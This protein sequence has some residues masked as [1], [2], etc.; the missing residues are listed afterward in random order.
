MDWPAW[1]RLGLALALGYGAWC[2]TF[3]FLQDRMIYPIAG[4]PGSRA[5]VPPG[6][7]VLSRSI[8]GGE[9]SAWFYPPPNPPAP[10]VI[11]FHGNGETIAK[12]GE[13]AAG[14]ARLG[15]GLLLVEYRGYG[16]S[17]GRPSQRSIVE[18]AVWFYDQLCGRPEVDRE[19]IVLHGRSL[20]GGFAVQLA[21]QRPAAGLVLES[22]FTSIAQLARRFGVPAGLL[23]TPLRT[24]EAL[25]TL[26]LPVLI[27]HGSRDA[28]V[29][30]SHGRALRDL[31]R[32][33]TYLE[34]PRG[35]N[36]LPGPE[37]AEEYWSAIE[38]FLNEVGR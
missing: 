19:Q 29:P 5:P 25:P 1:L 2:A 37:L 20:G 18:D 34:L 36:D 31:A 7:V 11:F 3:Y 35:H 15:V 30:V 32:R 10:A 23:R 13:T 6:V 17:A 26:D 21:A 4:L 27:I 14:Y 33:P 16:G 38:T 24:E 28:I 12:Q 9:V 8:P 22:T